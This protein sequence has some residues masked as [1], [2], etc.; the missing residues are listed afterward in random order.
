M[1]IEYDPKKDKTFILQRSSGDR[2]GEL[3]THAK[4][5]CATK[6]CCI[7]KPS[8]HRLSR[9][10]MNWRTDRGVMERICEHGVWHNDPDDTAS[11]KALGLPDSDGIHTCDGCC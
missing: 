9:A 8:K 4:G 7:H 3:A 2:I 6:Y 10:P 1:L 5:A 11:R